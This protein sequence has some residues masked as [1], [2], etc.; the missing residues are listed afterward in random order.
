MTPEAEKQA[1]WDRRWITLTLFAMILFGCLAGFNTWYTNR[2]IHRSNQLWCAMVIGLDDNY[3]AA[4]PGT[5]PART[6][7]FAR[8]VRTI[9]HELGCRDTAQP[10]IVYPTPSRSN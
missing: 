1:A 3:R 10:A 8:Q 5:L 7:V 4:P 2:A 9:R 6:M